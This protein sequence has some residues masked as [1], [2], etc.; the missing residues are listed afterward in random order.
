MNV[1]STGIGGT[2]YGAI[3]YASTAEVM[4]QLDGNSIEQVHQGLDSIFDL[5]KKQ[6]LGK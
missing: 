2:R 1:S 6:Y 3:A 5:V 4:F